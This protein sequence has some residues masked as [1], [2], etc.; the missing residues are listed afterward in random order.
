MTVPYGTFETLVLV[1]T[2]LLSSADHS[3]TY[4]LNRE[5]GPVVLPGGFELVGIEGSVAV[6]SSTWGE[7]KALFR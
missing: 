1:E 2:D 7:A 4:Y 3:G 5:L 6:E